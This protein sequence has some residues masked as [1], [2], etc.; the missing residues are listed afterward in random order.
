MKREAVDSSLFIS[1]GYDKEAEILEVEFA[2]GS[3]REYWGISPEMHNDLVKADS[4]GSFY[5]VHIRGLF[6]SYKVS[7]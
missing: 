3:V 5:N 4:V 6:Y 2:S 7:E 1:I